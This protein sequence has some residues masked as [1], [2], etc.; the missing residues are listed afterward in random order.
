M[1]LLLLLV[2]VV[3]VVLL[4]LLFLLLMVLHRRSV[5]R[6]WPLEPMLQQPN[7]YTVTLPLYVVFDVSA[8]AFTVLNVVTGI[9][10]QHSLNMSCFARKEHPLTSL[11]T[12]SHSCR[13]R[14]CMSMTSSTYLP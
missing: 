10:M 5:T 6:P 13:P 14:G 4:L 7:E 8:P 2:L 12:S 1:L 11:K 3:V 9:D